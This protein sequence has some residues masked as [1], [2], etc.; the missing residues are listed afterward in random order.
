MFL[1]FKAT[2]SAFFVDKDLKNIDVDAKEKNTLNIAL[3][4]RKPSLMTSDH[5]NKR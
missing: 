3:P 5:T 4:G 2:I 1:I